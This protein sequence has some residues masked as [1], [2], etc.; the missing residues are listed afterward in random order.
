M[1][2]S[3]YVNMKIPSLKTIALKKG[4]VH[5]KYMI[6]NNIFSMTFRNFSIDMFDDIWIPWSIGMK[7]GKIISI[8][9]VFCEM[10][11]L[12]DEKVEAGL[13]LKEHKIYFIKPINEEG[14]YIR[15]I[16]KIKNFV[17]V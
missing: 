2:L 8:D 6:D 10:E 15:E 12:W 13:W 4:W 7:E 3:K 17:K 1:Q 9:E 11:N 16:F 14:Y 5:Y